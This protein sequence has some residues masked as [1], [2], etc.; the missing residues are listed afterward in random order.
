MIDIGELKATIK[1]HG[2][3]EAVKSFETLQDKVAKTGEAIKN[4]AMA[5][6]A[7]LG[8][9]LVKAVSGA[10]EL[11]KACNKLQ[12]QT[13]AT[14]TEMKGLHDT[15][16]S[17]YANNYG[18]SYEDIANSLASVQQQTNLTGNELQKATE[19]A[20]ALR[21]TF[22]W[23]VDDTIRAVDM[24]MS[25]FG[26][27]SEQAYNLIAQGAQNGL[28]KNDN[29]LDSINEYSVHFQQLGLDAEDMFNMMKN[30]AEQGV[31]DYDKLGD[32]VK[33]FGIRAKDGSDGTKE[34]FTQLGLDA[35]KMT[36]AF[37]NGGTEAEKAFQQV[38]SALANCDD[39]VL[40]NQVGVAL[41]GRW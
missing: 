41:F 16:E 25:Q 13:G 11:Q 26:V 28:D 23:E 9:S 1:V 29:L 21:D 5:T 2:G 8:A 3:E 31:F 20:L 4:F 10:N 22:D 18:E 24:M 19:N 7:V 36:Q 35:D 6:G 39:K 33:E 37:A 14:D 12:S 32:A 30:G 40:Q 15:L 38:N 34:A 27:T 17:I